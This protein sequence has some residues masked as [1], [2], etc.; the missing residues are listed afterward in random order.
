VGTQSP[1]DV[2]HTI[3]RDLS[4][5]VGDQASLKRYAT[6]WC[7]APEYG[8]LRYR[9]ENAHAAAEVALVEAYRRVR[10][11]EARER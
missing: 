6:H 1:K 7:S 2:S 4:R 11:D 8:Y 5:I 3:T 10:L 9:L